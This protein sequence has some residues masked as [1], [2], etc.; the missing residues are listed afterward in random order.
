MRIELKT[1]GDDWFLCV[2]GKNL[3]SY[4]LKLHH[5]LDYYYGE[6]NEPYKKQEDISKEIN[7]FK[8]TDWKQFD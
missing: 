8:E 4:S 5:K 1:I 6:I 7:P 3:N 2:K